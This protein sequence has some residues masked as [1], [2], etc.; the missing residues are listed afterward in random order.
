MIG[1]KTFHLYHFIQLNLSSNCTSLI[2]W[3]SPSPSPTLGRIFQPSSNFMKWP[4]YVT[5]RCHLLQRCFTVR[6]RCLLDNA[7][8]FIVCIASC[9]FDSLVIISRIRSLLPYLYSVTGRNVITN[10]C[11]CS[12]HRFYFNIYVDDLMAELEANGSHV[13]RQY[14][15]CIIRLSRTFV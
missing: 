8:G 3:I 11:E 2:S 15:G 12:D 7:S 13:G 5:E 10:H 9:E 4:L 6:F 14:F 1:T